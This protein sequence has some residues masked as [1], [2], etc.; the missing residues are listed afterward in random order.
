MS[1]T[2]DSSTPETD[3]FESDPNADSA[4]GLAG[5][6]GVSSERPGTVR[7]GT[8]EVTYTAAPTHPGDDGV[9]AP[10]GDDVPPEQSAHDGEPDVHPDDDLP[11]HEFDPTRNPGHSGG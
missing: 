4:E 1:E 7:G 6:I 9:G 5:G 8:D 10:T 2:P 3:V 11:T